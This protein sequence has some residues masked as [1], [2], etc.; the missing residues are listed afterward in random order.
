MSIFGLQINGLHFVHADDATRPDG[1]QEVLGCHLHGKNR[2]HMAKL[3]T[4]E[5]RGPDESSDERA[6]N[7]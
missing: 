6:A 7:M 2:E 1:F 4:S 3:I 5:L